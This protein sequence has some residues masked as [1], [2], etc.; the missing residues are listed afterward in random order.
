MPKCYFILSY[1]D[2]HTLVMCAYLC[3]KDIS[4]YYNFSPNLLIIMDFNIVFS[5]LLCR[6][7]QLWK[8]HTLTTTNKVSIL[9]DNCILLLINNLIF[10]MVWMN[11]WLIP[12]WKVVTMHNVSEPYEQFHNE[13]TNWWQFPFKKKF[14]LR[15]Y[16]EFEWR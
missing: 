4:N 14:L 5:I 15:L 13:R 11:I 7:G 10:I 9:L 12:L 3:N 8:M 2:M 16:S 1:K 6:K